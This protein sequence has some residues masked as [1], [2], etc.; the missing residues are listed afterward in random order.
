MGG[1][2]AKVC[3]GT[4]P[5]PQSLG[6]GASDFATIWIA[7]WGR[8]ASTCSGPVKSSCVKSG[9]MTKPILNDDMS[10]LQSSAAERCMGLALLQYFGEATYP[11]ASGNTKS[12]SGEGEARG[13]TN[14]EHTCSWWP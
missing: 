10:D 13:R 6:T 3:V 12:C 1:Q 11:S 9:K 4:S 5:R 14:H 7:D 2:F 8:R